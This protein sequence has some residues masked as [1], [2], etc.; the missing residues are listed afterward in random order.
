MRFCTAADSGILGTGRRLDGSE[1][2]SGDPVFDTR[3]CITL[4]ASLVTTMLLSAVAGTIYDQVGTL[5]GRDQQ[6]LQRYGGGQQP[7]ISSDLVELL[8]VR[9]RQV[10]ETSVSRVQNPKAILARL[11]LQVRK[12]FAIDQNRVSEDLRHPGRFRFRRH[13]IIELTLAIERPVVD[14]QRGISYLPRGRFEPSS[15][16]SRMTKAP[17]DV[18]AYMF[19]RVMPRRVVVMS[20]GITITLADFSYPC[21]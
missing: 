14:G 15:Y 13:G 11:D 16:S 17:K 1:L 8:S 19:R 10:K 12:H 9:K 5:R 18:P 3:N 7:E 6:A 4:K 2:V 21:R 20:S